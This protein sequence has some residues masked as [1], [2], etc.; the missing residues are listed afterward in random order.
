MAFQLLPH[1]TYT[2]DRLGAIALQIRQI[3]LQYIDRIE[4]TNMNDS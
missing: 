3:Q 4:I 2:A 1:E